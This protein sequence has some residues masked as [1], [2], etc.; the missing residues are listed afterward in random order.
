MNFP[1]SWE[2]VLKNNEKKVN[3]LSSFM[4]MDSTRGKIKL[5]KNSNSFIWLGG[6][7]LKEKLNLIR[8]M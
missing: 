5:G 1:Y 7:I 3:Y 4:I 2:Q 8:I 6:R